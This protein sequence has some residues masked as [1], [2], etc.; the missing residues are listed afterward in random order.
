MALSG[1]G[2]KGGAQ[3]TNFLVDIRL[4]S[5][6][7]GNLF[8][9]ERAVPYAKLMQKTLHRRLRNSERVAKDPDNRCPTV[10]S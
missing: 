8:P 4:R 5:D 1:S 6:G 7:L 2:G 10:R 9:Q 3:I